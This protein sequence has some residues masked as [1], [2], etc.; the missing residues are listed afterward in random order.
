[1]LSAMLLSGSLPMSSAEM[2]S[3]MASA[4]FFVL[5]ALSMPRR[6]PVTV[7]TW[8]AALAPAAGAVWACAT[9]L[10]ISM[11]ATAAATGVACSKA[12]RALLRGFEFFMACLLRLTG[13]RQLPLST[14]RCGRR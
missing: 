2:L 12:R 10:A 14:C 8:G 7:I 3:T 5:M 9:P 11:A 13:S 6:M 1:M 4:F